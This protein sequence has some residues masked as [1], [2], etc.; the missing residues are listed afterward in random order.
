MI[1]PLSEVLTSR[2]YDWELRGRGWHVFETPVDPEPEFYPFFGHFAPAPAVIDDGKRHTLMSGLISLFQGKKE[3]VANGDDTLTEIPPVQAYEYKRDEKLAAYRVVLPKGE[4]LQVED[5]EQLLLMLSYT[6]H[7]VSFEIIATSVSIGMQFACR[8]SDEMHVYGQ[9]KAYFPTAVITKSEAG[10]EILADDTQTCVLDFGLTDEFMRPL[11]MAEDVEHDPYVGLF[12]TLEHLLKGERGV[13]QIL[14][15][16]TGNP[17]AES[18]MRSVT[19]GRGGS[20]FADAPDM[21]KYAQEK[22]ST[23]LYAVC[24]K[25]AGQADKSDRAIDIAKTIGSALIRLTGSHGNRLQMLTQ[26]GYP[27]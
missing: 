16:G 22:V 12:A 2:F 3:L 17:W 19:D 10:L 9:C 23:P 14:F 21:V 6:A 11:A 27:R 8:E 13:I 7:P 15:K 4:K 5:I 20:F 24:I 18:I 26:N 1:Q 25:V